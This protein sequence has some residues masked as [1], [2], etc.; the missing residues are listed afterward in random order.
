MINACSALGSSGRRSS[1]RPDIFKSWWL[2]SFGYALAAG[3]LVYFIILYRAGTWI[4]GKTGLPIYTDFSVWWAGALQALH[5]N[6]ADLYDPSAFAKIQAALFGPGAAFYPN[7]P[8]YPPT[9]FFVLAP[10]ALLPYGYAFI[11]WDVATLLGCIA[12]VYLIVRHRAAIAM[13]LAA[14]FTAWNFIAAQNGFLTA[15]LL[16]ASLLSLERSPVLAGVFIGCLTYK[17]QFGILLPVALVAARQWRTIATAAITAALL[18]A[19][20][21]ALFGVETWTGFP[22]GLIAQGKLNLAADADSNWGYLQTVYGLVRTLHGSST[23]AWLAQG[24]TT[25]G[26]AVIVWIVW[27]S[28]AS[29]ALKAAALS[30]AALL[31]TPYAFA[32][33]MAALMVPAAFLAQDQLRRGLLRG[34]KAMWIVLFGAPLALLV[35]LGDNAAQTTFGGT[36]ASLLATVTLLAAIVRRGLVSAPP[37]CVSGASSG[38]LRA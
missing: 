35:T 25:L 29:H 19:G 23:R 38:I 17:P 37:P 21:I 27:R 1:R 31:A 15:S 6:P 18:D 33:D 24:M 16:G 2:Q 30:A 34:E 14:P 20:S 9:F 4:L 8:S 32:Y 36:P 28:R 13:A 12:V 22:Q 10:L 26:T 5:G 11:T 7:W 3:Y